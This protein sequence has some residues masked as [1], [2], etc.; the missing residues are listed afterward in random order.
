M[1][2]LQMLTVTIFSILIIGCIEEATSPEPPNRY[3]QGIVT[4]ANTNERIDTVQVSWMEDGS[5]QFVYTDDLGYFST[6]NLDPGEYSLTFQGPNGYS[7]TKVNVEVPSL[8]D[9]LSSL[10]V[11]VGQDLSEDLSITQN[12]NLYQSNAG[13]SGHVFINRDKNSVIPAQ[14]GEVVLDYGGYDI[15]P[16]LYT[17]SIGDSGIFNFQNIPATE[18]VVVRILPIEFEGKLFAGQANQISLIPGNTVNSGNVVLNIAQDTPIIIRN[19]VNNNTKFGINE[20]IKLTYS[21]SIDIETVNISLQ[22]NQS[23][24]NP[25][26]IQSTWEDSIKVSIHPNVSL[27]KDSEYILRIR[28]NSSDGNYFENTLRFITEKGLEILSTNLMATD[29]IVDEFPVD[30]IIQFEFSSAVNIDNDRGYID[31]FQNNQLV[32]VKTTL[33][34]NDKTLNI[35]PSEPLEPSTVYTLDFKVYSDSTD[36]FVRDEDVFSPLNFQTVS[37]NVPFV[38]NSNFTNEDQK[39]E[40]QSDIWMQF[41]EPLNPDTTLEIS[42]SRQPD[43]STK[44][45]MS[46]EFGSQNQVLTITPKVQLQIETE[47]YLS[48]NAYSSTRGIKYSDTLSFETEDGIE[49]IGTNLERLDGVFDQFPIDEEI[50]IEFSK[51]INISN[52]DGYVILEDQDNLEV[53]TSISTSDDS[54][55]F[56]TPNNTL[57][58]GQI[59]SLNFRVYST[60]EEDNVNQNFSFTT[61]IS[62]SVPSIVRDFELNMDDF[63][64]DSVDWDTQNLTF[65]WETMDDVEEYL[66][67]ASDTKENTDLVK[68]RTVQANTFLPTQS[69]TISI[70]QQFDVVKDQPGIT[71]FVAGNTISFYIVASNTAGKGELSSAIELS[72]QM[73]PEGSA[74]QTGSADNSG[75]TESKTIFISFTASEYLDPAES[76]G[77]HFNIVEAGGDSNYKIPSSNV[78]FEW[79]S[80]YTGGEFTIE[81][82]AGENGSGDIFSIQNLD[83]SSENTM[84]ESIDITLF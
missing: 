34:D 63:T 23:G 45:L 27:R 74:N 15:S 72:D 20:D 82:P 61:E 84:L 40:V 43:F 73:P 41:S 51:P 28:G 69:T 78:S 30:G 81:I 14:S 77:A 10:N 58:P 1:R 60:I 70:P 57:E 53:F 29:G 46:Y 38:T 79:N 39:V 66:I 67:Y 48:I 32:Q 13:L 36:S 31:L 76:P 68:I 26:A 12:V 42:L 8:K 64:A 49:I 5:R 62:Q 16:K 59:Y 35:E 22:R 55:L 7:L 6:T 17:T 21:K 11:P 83:D 80:N 47:Y 33:T 2:A 56:I 44:T 50:Q 37:Y 9:E 19:N 71:P 3:I 52:S 18:D 65:G 24:A 4:D 54:I 75:Q 25:V